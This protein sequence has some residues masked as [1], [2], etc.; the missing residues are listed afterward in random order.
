MASIVSAARCGRENKSAVS[1][2][3]LHLSRQSRPSVNI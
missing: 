1:V 2:N 3:F